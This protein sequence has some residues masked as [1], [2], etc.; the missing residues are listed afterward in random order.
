MSVVEEP[1]C[2]T[3]SLSWANRVSLN[4]SKVS[5]IEPV[6]ILKNLHRVPG[7]AKGTRGGGTGDQVILDQVQALQKSILDM[8]KAQE[9]QSK[10]KDKKLATMKA[11]THIA[12]INISADS[13][14]QH[15][16][17][18]QEVVNH[19]E[20]AEKKMDQK[21]IDL[22]TTFTEKMQD[23]FK[24]VGKENDDKFQLLIQM[25]TVKNQE[26]KQLQENIVVNNHHTS[27]YLMSRDPNQM[28]SAA[29][30]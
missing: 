18:L 6:P 16:V 25:M 24:N 29:Q 8:Q 22:T 26:T 4:P 28:S 21:M 17:M 3:P 9:E 7:G 20:E 14:K 5:P 30:S 15:R 10:D 19:Q 27:S 11:E 13:K 1:K 2:V 23:S 12:F